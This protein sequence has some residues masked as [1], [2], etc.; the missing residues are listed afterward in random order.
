[1]T[2]PIITPKTIP[3]SVVKDRASGYSGEYCVRIRSNGGKE[4]VNHAAA[5]GAGTSAT[6]ARWSA[7]AGPMPPPRPIRRYSRLASATTHR[8][9]LSWPGQCRVPPIAQNTLMTPSRMQ[10]TETS[11]AR[12]ICSCRVCPIGFSYAVGPP[13]A[14]GHRA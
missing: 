13:N 2:I 11:L 4:V 8:G 5:M 6:H 14:S 9:H 1:M 3:A 7:P 10:P 12:V